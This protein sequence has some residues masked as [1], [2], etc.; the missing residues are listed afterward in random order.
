MALLVNH[1]EQILVQSSAEPLSTAATRSNAKPTLCVCVCV[2]VHTGICVNNVL[3]FPLRAAG[4]TRG[5]TLIRLHYQSLV[6][7]TLARS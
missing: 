6:D 4:M 2:S 5:N 3:D 7:P 1:R